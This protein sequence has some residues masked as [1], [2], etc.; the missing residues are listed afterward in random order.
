MDK[1]YFEVLKWA[2]SFLEEQG[3]EGYSIQFL[4]LERKGWSKTDWLIHMREAMPAG[5]QV[6]VERDLERLL[7][8]YP[9][10]YLL[11]Y[12]DF[13]EHRFLVNEHTLI[14]RPE[15]EELVALCLKETTEAPMTVVDVGTGT[16]AIAISLKL[17]RSAWQ[18][19]AVDIS[20]ETLA[21]AQENAARLH[22]PVDFFLGDVLAPVSDQRFDII[23]SNPPYIGA[24]EWPEMD[25]SVRKY[26]PKAALFA[27]DAGLAIY[28]RLAA[29][30][31]RVIK[32]QGKI[33][34][35]IGYLQGA[36]VQAIFQEA[37]PDKKVEV[38]KDFSGQDRMI[39][40]HD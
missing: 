19:A 14:P 16:G 15:T 34:L 38:K 39:Y 24:E 5:E 12:A 6:W 4:F 40:V 29:E 20:P 18:I 17:A 32:P 26:E 7:A 8:D 21:V 22:A 36:A 1:T 2:S 37:Y 27:E 31:A 11:G 25:A 23:I 30:S 10:Q 28:R 3:K 35:E 13:F 33:F 9:P